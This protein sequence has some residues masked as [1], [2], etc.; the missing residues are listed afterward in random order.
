MNI[1][2]Q[3][4]TDRIIEHIKTQAAVTDKTVSSEE[5]KK[6]NENEAQ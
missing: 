3:V 1:F 5:F 2:E 6:L 4:L